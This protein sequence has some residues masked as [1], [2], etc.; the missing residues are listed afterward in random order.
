MTEVINPHLDILGREIS[1]GMPVAV[2][3]RTGG[4]KICT[5]KLLTPKMVRVEPVQRQ[6]LWNGKDMSYLIYASDTV[7]IG[8]EDVLM[9]VLK[10]GG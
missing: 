8:G 2:A 10:H 7:I 3:T 9:Y 4:L 1:V 6:K 5:V